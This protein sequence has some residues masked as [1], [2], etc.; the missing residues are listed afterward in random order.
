MLYPQHRS[1]QQ[2]CGV[3]III[4]LLYRWG[5]WGPER[6]GHLPGVTQLDL[7]ELVSRPRWSNFQGLF[8]APQATISDLDSRLLVLYT[9]TLKHKF[10]L[11]SSMALQVVPKLQPSPHSVA[12]FWGLK[13]IY[14]IL[15]VSRDNRPQCSES[16]CTAHLHPTPT[17]CTSSHTDQL[18]KWSQSASV[19]S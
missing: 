14:L 19:L 6:L 11:I 4:I 7:A 13:D 16:L 15:E 18:F 10:Y 1:S 5:S 2:L 12:S 17:T 9:H 3:R 8:L